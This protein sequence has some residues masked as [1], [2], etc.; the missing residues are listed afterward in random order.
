MLSRVQSYNYTLDHQG[1]TVEVS[2]QYTQTSPIEF[3]GSEQY[4]TQY[5]I[6]SVPCAALGQTDVFINTPNITIPGDTLSSIMYWACRDATQ[7]GTYYIYL[8]GIYLASNSIGNITCTV[9][10]LQPATYSVMYESNKGIFTTTPLTP[11]PAG[12]ASSAFTSPVM[13]YTLHGLGNFMWGQNSHTTNLLIESIIAFAVKDF[14]QWPPNRPSDTYLQ[15]YGLM[16]KG[17]VEYLV[18]VSIHAFFSC[19]YL[20]VDTS[21]H[22]HSVVIFNVP[23]G[24]FVLSPASKR[25]CELRSSR[26]VRKD[27]R[28]FRFGS[29][30]AGQRIC[31]LSASWSY[32]SRETRR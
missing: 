16:F 12:S 4:S 7:P 21:D 25:A 9:S 15:L 26:L 8:R 14:D 3:F 28:H 27:S 19:G 1:I 5:L 30:H 22:V 20:I 29:N 31:L 13:S 23:R 10:Q 32:V 6:Y 18:C 2:C 17:V 11:G 24:S